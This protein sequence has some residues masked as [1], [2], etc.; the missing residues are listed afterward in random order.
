MR[1]KRFYAAGMLL[2]AVTACS[3]DPSG[4]TTATDGNIE[5]AAM[6]VVQAVQ[7]LD[8]RVPIIAGREAYLRVFP[9]S[10]RPVP[11][12]TLRVRLYHGSTLLST[13]DHTLPGGSIP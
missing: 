6:Y 12:P 4:P 7:T 1:A 3:D 8:N 13:T 2:L 5:M 10:D 11:A 9:K